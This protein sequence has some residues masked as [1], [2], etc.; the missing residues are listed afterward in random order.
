MTLAEW[1]A[2]KDIGDAEMAALV[3]ADRSTISRIR[4]GKA[5]PSWQLAARIAKVTAR[6]VK[7]DTYLPSEAA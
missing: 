4:R 1:M 3:D 2:A 5:R 6:K 7:T